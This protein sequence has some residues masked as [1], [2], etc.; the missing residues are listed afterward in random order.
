MSVMSW[1][2]QLCLRGESVI[3]APVNLAI[4]TPPPLVGAILCLAC[5]ALPRSIVHTQCCLLESLLFFVISKAACLFMWRPSTR[6][7]CARTTIQGGSSDRTAA[8]SQNKG[9]RNR[10]M[11]LEDAGGP[12]SWLESL[13]HLLGAWRSMS[14]W[15]L[16]QKGCG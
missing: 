3:G 11:G 7:V 4:E 13:C 1:I 12:W 15:P 10:E 2:C 16:I 5:I 14:R 6:P 9:L 8:L